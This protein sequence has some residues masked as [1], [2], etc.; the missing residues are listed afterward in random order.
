[1][2]VSPRW[3]QD[4]KPAV[5]EEEVVDIRGM[6]QLFNIFDDLAL[7]VPIFVAHELV[8]TD[9][10]GHDYGPHHAGLREALRRTDAR[11]GMVL[12]MLER[13]GLLE[14][15][16]FV[17]TADH[18]MASQ[19]VELR[20]NPAR[21]PQRFGIKGIFAEPTIYLRD[22]AIECTRARDGRTVRV[23]VKDNDAAPDG[24]LP[25]VSGASVLVR[26]PDQQL[27]AEAITDAH[28]IAALATP[29]NLNDSEISIAVDH[30]DFNSRRIRADG[31]PIRIDLIKCLYG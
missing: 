2:D 8:L 25:I 9:G 11:V 6:A 23:T 28:G 31:S 27:I 24:E 7:P 15:T 26:G 20:A 16:L 12:R 5:E 18:G 3:A 22:M 1:M 30:P 29:A 13:K 4:H 19:Q 14:S 10:A 17:V 21:E